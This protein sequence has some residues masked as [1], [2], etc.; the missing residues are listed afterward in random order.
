MSTVSRRKV[1]EAGLALGAAV[2]AG[3]FYLVRAQQARPIRIGVILSYSGVYTRLGQEITR[4]MELYLEKVGNQAGGRPIQLIKEDEEADPAVALRKARKLVESDGVDL[5]AGVILTPSVYALRDYIHERQIP[6]IV[7]NAAANGVT[8]G[9]NKS[10]YLFRVSVTAWQPAYPFGRW[11][12]ENVSRRVFLL[13]ADYG[14]GRESIAAFK[15]SYVP[16]GGQAVD[17]VYTPLGSTDF[18][19]VISRI[20]ALRPEAVFA[21]LSGSDAVIFMRQFV[22]FGLNR[23]VRLAVSGETVDETVL[24]AIGPAAVGALSADQ[25]VY[26]LDTPANQNFIREYRERYRSVPNHFAVR[27]YD[28]AQVIVQ[29]LDAVQGDLS[30]KSRFIQAM[31]RV[32]IDSPRGLIEFDPATHQVIEN[33]YVREVTQTPEGLVNRLVANLGRVR[34]PDV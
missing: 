10:P 13:A 8:R 16:A 19:A 25:W 20:G 34:D 18:S 32:R 27:G 31:E 9:A 26:T 11:V 12:A 1:L 14:F 17:E 5:L 28:T 22:Q 21:V 15:E 29:A 3:R 2:G 30:D 33:V 6:L 7:S 23:T 4:G 24:E